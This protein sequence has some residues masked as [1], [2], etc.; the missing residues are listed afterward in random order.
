VRTLLSLS[1]KVLDVDRSHVADGL[2]AIQARAVED[3]AALDTDRRAAL[4]GAFVRGM[5]RLDVDTSLEVERQLLQAAKLEPPMSTVFA[6]DSALSLL[7]VR[8]HLRWVLLAS[9]LRWHEM[10]SMLAVFG[11]VFRC[12]IHSDSSVEIR[13]DARHCTVHL[14]CKREFT[15]KLGVERALLRD[16]CVERERADGIEFVIEKCVTSKESR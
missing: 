3:L 10:Q 7:T 13:H 1:Q 11:T 15:T 9:R 5:R 16:V 4:I 14:R 12:A 6:M 2:E 8:G